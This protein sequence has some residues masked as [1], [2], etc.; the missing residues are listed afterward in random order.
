M[1]SDE[2]VYFSNLSFF[3]LRGA[4]GIPNC[5]STKY[6]KTKKYCDISYPG[7]VLD[8]ANMCAPK[9]DYCSVYKNRLCDV[10]ITGFF[11]KDSTCVRQSPECQQTDSRGLCTQC[12]PGFSVKHGACAKDPVIVN[13]A[14]SEYKNT[15]GVCV[16]GDILNCVKYVSPSGQCETCISG[17]TVNSQGQCVFTCPTQT[18]TKKFVLVNGK[19]VGTDI[20]CDLF[21]G[22]GSCAF[23]FTGFYVSQGKCI[24]QGL[25][26]SSSTVSVSSS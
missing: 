9:V 13:C 17:F 7:Y 1:G 3:L 6:I 2:S 14:A 18:E 15:D 16:E 4:D 11:L 24:R 8:S 26:S 19:C 22:D 23:C 12:Q 5:F 20:N 10:C 21:N 25:S